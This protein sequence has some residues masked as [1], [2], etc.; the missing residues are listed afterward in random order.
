MQW[1]WPGFYLFLVLKF[2]CIFQFP[3]TKDQQRMA[4]FNEKKAKLKEEEEPAAE[5]EEEPAAEEEEGAA[6]EAEEEEEEEECLGFA[7]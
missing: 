4:E 2:S 3:C 7:N 6:E 5:G 1:C